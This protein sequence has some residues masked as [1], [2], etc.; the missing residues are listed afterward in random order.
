M[1][2]SVNPELQ[3]RID[4]LADEGGRTLSA[5]ELADVIG[6]VARSLTADLDP[7]R[8]TLPDTGAGM[9]KPAVP[10]EAGPACDLESA[11]AAAAKIGTVDQ[12]DG[13]LASIAHDLEEIRSATQDAASKFLASAESIERISDQPDLDPDD[14]VALT[15]LSTEMFEASGFQDLT[16]Q[17]LTR[18]CEFLRQIEYL[19]VSAK[20]ALGDEAAATA[21]EELSHKVEETEQRKMEYKL[22]GPE[23]AGTANTQEEIDKIL[24]SFD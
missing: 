5:G 15:Q 7:L 6:E 20:A 18:I 3:N 11:L 1:P 17:R 21:A 23:D 16:G 10:A 9:E 12:G 4:S 2:R 19:A 13:P 14:Q 24:A 22:H 8:S